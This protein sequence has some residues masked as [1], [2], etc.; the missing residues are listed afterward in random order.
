MNKKDLMAH[1][2]E[3]LRNVLESLVHSALEAKEAATNE[4]SKPENKY[5]TRG[6]EAS[7]LAGAQALRAEELKRSIALLESLNLADHVDGSKPRVGTL[8]HIQINGEKEKFL[9]LLPTAGGTKATFEGKEVLVVTP[10]SPVGQLLL[11]TEEGESFDFKA[12]KNPIYYEILE[13]I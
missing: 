12:G 6:L 9:F 13:L 5:D 8:I 7:Y 2:L 1:L 4:E 3:D 11:V 10:D